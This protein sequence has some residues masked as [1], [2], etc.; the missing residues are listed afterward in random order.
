MIKTITMDA[1]SGKRKYQQNCDPR[2]GF[3]N[4]LR[5]TFLF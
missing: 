2:N 1:C 4:D 3:Y 5:K